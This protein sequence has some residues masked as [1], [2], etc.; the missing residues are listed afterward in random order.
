[1]SNNK[2]GAKG[3]TALATALKTNRSIRA[4]GLANNN[5]GDEGAA[6]IAEALKSNEALETL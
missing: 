5:M 2:F 1:M 4:M 6:Q 3:A